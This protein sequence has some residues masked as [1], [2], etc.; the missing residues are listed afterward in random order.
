MSAAS[1][2]SVP[3]YSALSAHNT[4]LLSAWSAGDTPEDVLQW[5]KDWLGPDLPHANVTLVN[6]HP[7]APPVTSYESP[8]FNIVKS[9]IQQVW[10]ADLPVLPYLMSGGT[11]SKHYSHLTKAILRFCPY[12]LGNEDVH[13]VHG[14][15]ERISVEDFGRLLC[16]YKAG[17]QLAAA[18]RP[19]ESGMGPGG[20]LLG[21]VGRFSPGSV[22][23]V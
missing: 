16:T 23:A 15:N 21:R 22:A 4:D 17:L 10:G 2:T 11:D 9:A 3:Q 5:T 13:R 6:P 12:A 18:R 14:T 20:A 19:G 8:Q 7:G 1:T